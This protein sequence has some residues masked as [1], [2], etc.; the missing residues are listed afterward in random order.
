MSPTAAHLLNTDVVPFSEDHGMPIKTMLS[1]TIVADVNRPGFIGGSN[2]WEGGAMTSKTTNKF[3]P[4]ARGRAVRLRMPTVPTGRGHPSAQA[5][6]V[7]RG[8]RVRD[9]G[10]GG[11]VQ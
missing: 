8:R 1:E 11:L 4:E 2:C 7:V 9:L 10:M 6:T 3:S 5:L